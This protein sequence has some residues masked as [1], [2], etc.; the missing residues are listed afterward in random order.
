MYDNLGLE[1]IKKRYAT[2]SSVTP[3][4]KVPRRRVRTN[5]W[6]RLPLRVLDA[7]DSQV[8]S[9]RNRDLIEPYRRKDHTRTYWGIRIAFTDYKL[10]S[11]PLKCVIRSPAPLA[12]IPT[13]LDAMPREVRGR[14][15]NWG[16]AVCEAA[17]ARTSTPRS[18]PAWRHDL[19]AEKVSLLK[20]VLSY[21][22][23]SPARFSPAACLRV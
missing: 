1:T 2:L 21:E 19:A 18:K 23:A 4:K 11:D 16:Y 20:R 3:A 17:C 13:R 7:V 12:A 9:L 8:R 15:M 6:A 22:A 5:D 10:A 14:L